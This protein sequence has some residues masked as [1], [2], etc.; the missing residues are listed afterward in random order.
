MATVPLITPLMKS[1]NILKVR[2]LSRH[3]G[4]IKALHQVDL[5][6][7][8]GS[9]T[10]LIGPNGSGKTTL[11][12]VISGMD[13]GATGDIHF[14]D[15]PILGL[16]PSQIYHRGLARTFQLSQIFPGLTVLE[17][18]LVAGAGKKEDEQKAKDLLAQVNMLDYKDVDGGGLSYGQQR[19]IEFVRALMND[20]VMILLD[21][22]AAGV[23][24]TLRRALW[25]IV[26]KK[27]DQ[28]I[29]ILLIEHNMNVISD[30]CDT[31][32]VL[33]EGQMLAHGTFTEIRQN[34]QVMEAYFG[35]AKQG[36]SP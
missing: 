35:T 26:R 13:Q 30:L 14:K 36:E 21:E 23:N 20:P 24:P 17:N 31:V 8:E 12:Q 34:E 18:L 9:I 22:P 3:F 4:G 10:G 7:A 6:I 28:G 19:L 32:Y 27:R 1:N 5:D 15:K 2:S 33:N 29:T 25:K 16:R 11:F